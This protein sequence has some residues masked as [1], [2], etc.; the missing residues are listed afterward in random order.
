VRISATHISSIQDAFDYLL[1]HSG[2]RSASA[3]P[4]GDASLA[5]ASTSN[6]KMDINQ[7]NA[8]GLL[9]SRGW[10]YA[11]KYRPLMLVYV[12]MFVC[13]MG[14]LLYEPYVIGRMLN[15][16]QVDLAGGLGN[17]SKLLSDV[18]HYL[19]IILGISI[20]FWSFHGPARVLERFVAFQI[21]SSFKADLFKRIT[22][23]PIQWQR[24]H[25]SG[26]TIDKINR[27]TI[28][29]SN[30]FQDSFELIY[31]ILRLTGT[32]TIL[33][34]VMP[35]AGWSA[36]AVTVLA[37][38]TI[39]L[40]DSVM[41]KQYD[42]LNRK[43]NHVASA[44]HDYVSNIISVITL[45]LELRTLAEVTRRIFASQSLFTHNA[46]LNELKWGVT[47]LMVSVM[48]ISVMFWYVHSNLSAKHLILAGTF[49]TLFE[50]LR[51]IGES[52]YTFAAYYGVVVRQA[53]DLRGA[54]SIND[55]YNALDLSHNDSCL[56]A[57][58]R[59]LNVNQLNFT[60]ED[61]KHRTHHLKNVDLNLKKGSSIAFVGESGSGK[62]TL[63][64]LL[65]GLQKPNS[66]EV[67]ADGASLEQG[68]K[69]LAHATTL[70]PQDPE[71]FADTIR[72]NITFGMEATDEEIMTALKLARFDGVLSR[73]PLG[74]DTNIAEKGVNLSGGEKQRLA[75][76]RGIFF[77]KDSDL[78]LMDEPT[79]S[80]DTANERY[81]YSALM[82]HFSDRC[83]IS[84][85]HKLHLLELFDHIYVLA[86]GEIVESG[87]FQTLVT[88]GGL[89]S[90]MWRN[91][92]IGGDVQPGTGAAELEAAW[93]T[94]PLAVS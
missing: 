23:L 67:S 29:I 36:L 70:M 20:G 75:L 47:S 72:F 78:I 92:Q 69:H 37:L 54:D 3:T 38:A 21:R 1:E 5:F 77:A 61:E 40:F 27:A 76:A 58:W 85:I 33:F 15:D 43:D 6:S 10:R 52:F 62:S 90:R 88:K 17:G 26:E 19:L 83:L 82:E 91:Y 56:P 68:L 51:R 89:L 8:I 16:V 7:N 2:D 84:S 39:A 50:Y 71:I 65:R 34:C 48:T 25:H 53:A 49:F 46:K 73:L 32:L 22:S 60:Y 41:N 28:A 94:E 18:G 55:V 87:D 80:V 24:E 12:L 13:A 31:M 66:V 9:F 57:G 93:S 11:G 35:V 42:E 30:F 86:N 44:L 64:T 59:E 81:I 4:S 14:F 45:R 74:L 79:S 63:L